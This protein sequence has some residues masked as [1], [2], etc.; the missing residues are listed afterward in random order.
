VGKYKLLSAPGGISGTAPKTL[1]LPEG[2]KATAAIEDNT[3]V[4]DLTTTP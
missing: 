2:W 1:N 4:L 3:L